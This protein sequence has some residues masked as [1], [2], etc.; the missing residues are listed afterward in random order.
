MRTMT[1]VVVVQLLAECLVPFRSSTAGQPR[2]PEL[3]ALRALDAGCASPCRKPAVVFVHGIAG[4]ADT[5]RTREGLPSWPDLMKQDSD[6]SGRFSIY[7]LDYLTH[8]ETT[9]RRIGT[10]P[11]ANNLVESIVRVAKSTLARH[12]SV[13]FVCHSLGGNIARHYLV[14]MSIESS[15][16]LSRYKGLFLLGT[17]VEGSS[18]A[19]YANA[20]G[21]LR[22]LDPK[23]AG[24]SY[25]VSATLMA[26]E[27]NDYLRFLNQ[28]WSGLVKAATKRKQPIDVWA[29][30]EKK[31]MFPLPIIVTEQSATAAVPR[32]LNSTL[33]TRDRVCGFDKDHFELA[34]PSGLDDLV[35][36]WVK[37]ELLKSVG[38]RTLDAQTCR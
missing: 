22:A 12:P 27:S 38:A 30:Y 19:R 15:E 14:L 33:P 9:S 23:S 26:L 25:Q 28:L 32:T 37:G 11:T 13:Y 24:G 35:Y 5:W 7:E 21:Q 18:L 10:I 8:T 20:A 4:A 6:L 2:R 17:P 31:S 34:K 16:E 29:A 36:V 1:I 3:A